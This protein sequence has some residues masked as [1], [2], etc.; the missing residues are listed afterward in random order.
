MPAN[1]KPHWHV[2][3]RTFAIATRSITV[4]QWQQFLNDRPNLPRNSEKVYSPDPAGPVT[5]LSWFLAAQYCNWLS[6]KEGIPKDQWCYPDEIK[7]GMKPYPDYLRRIGYRLP[8]EAEWEYACR[9]E[10][11]SSRS[12]GSPIEL[13]PRY[14]FFQFNSQGRM[15][16]VGQKR[17]NDLGLF[18]MHG[19][20]WTWCQDAAG[21]YPSGR[22]EDVE[23]IRD[24][25]DSLYRI[26][27]GGSFAHLG[28][29]IRSAVRLNNRPAEGSMDV[30]LRIA[31]TYR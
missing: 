6:E 16:P 21:P 14:A 18:D 27:R 9:A 31:R 28:V 4:A 8:T 30:G 23:D 29:N 20:V 25:S 7:E 5:Q 2:I 17:P 13:L 11:V 10:T 24:F 19:N 12:Y 15:W 22:V 26:I 3:G 1:E